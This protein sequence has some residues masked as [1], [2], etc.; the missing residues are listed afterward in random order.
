MDSPAGNFEIA[1]AKA[2]QTKVIKTV[3]FKKEGRKAFD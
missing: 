2:K 1:A 3:P